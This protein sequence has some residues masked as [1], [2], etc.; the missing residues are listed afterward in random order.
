[1][2][3]S[4]IGDMYI[5]DGRLLAW[6]VWICISSVGRD[7]AMSFYLHNKATSLYG[8]RRFE[9]RMRRVYAIQTSRLD[10]QRG[11]RVGAI[12][13]FKIELPYF[14]KRCNNFA[15]VALSNFVY[16]YLEGTP[17][18]WMCHKTRSN[19]EDRRPSQTRLLTYR[20]C[21]FNACDWH[22]GYSLCFQLT[23][24]TQTHTHQPPPHT[25]SNSN[26][27]NTTLRCTLIYIQSHWKPGSL[28]TARSYRFCWASLYRYRQRTRQQSSRVLFQIYE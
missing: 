18:A 19:C 27:S 23:R 9:T 21:S 22:I 20:T 2:C 14:A 4:W 5:T 25:H 1:M 28:P 10:P 6:L 12:E 17:C 3:R 8:F 11:H 16:I 26:H 13:T 7:R 24:Y 15:M